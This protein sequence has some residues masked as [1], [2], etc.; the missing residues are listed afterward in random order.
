MR[1]LA[2][3]QYDDL[4]PR[5]VWRTVT[6]DVPALRDYVVRIVIPGLRP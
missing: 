1:N 6:Q 4:Q 3:H 2:A 5:R